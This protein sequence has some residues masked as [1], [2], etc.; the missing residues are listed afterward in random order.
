MITIVA[1]HNKCCKHFG[2][3]PLKMSQNNSF[4]ACLYFLSNQLLRPHIMPNWTYC[5]V[6]FEQ[7]LMCGYYYTNDTNSFSAVSALSIVGVYIIYLYNE[8]LN[9]CK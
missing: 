7:Y 2:N 3:F 6:D 4:F 1:L 5:C 8:R 9:Y